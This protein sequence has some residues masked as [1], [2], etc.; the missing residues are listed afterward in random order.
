MNKINILSEHL[1]KL[2]STRI[3]QEKK[4]LHI[5]YATLHMCNNLKIKEKIEK[6]QL[7]VRMDMA[8]FILLNNCRFYLAI[9]LFYFALFFRKHNRRS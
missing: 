8:V 6:K 3:Q 2:K 4:K 5:L 9:F 1:Y 7:F